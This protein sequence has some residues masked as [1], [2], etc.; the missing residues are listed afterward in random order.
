MFVFKTLPYGCWATAVC[1]WEITYSEKMPEKVFETV[2]DLKGDGRPC[3]VIREELR[4]CLLASDC[5]KVVN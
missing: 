3:S 1:L 2:E 4:D 5:C